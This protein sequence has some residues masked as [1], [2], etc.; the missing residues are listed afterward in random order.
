V[1]LLAPSSEENVKAWAA[2]FPG[3]YANIEKIPTDQFRVVFTSSP[4]VK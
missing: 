2:I 1:Q 4:I 3:F